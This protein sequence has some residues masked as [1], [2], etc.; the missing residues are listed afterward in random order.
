M[1][2]ALRPYLSGLRF[3]VVLLGT[4]AVSAVR[5]QPTTPPPP[6]PPRAVTL[7]IPAERT[8]GNG[9]R[10]IAVER[11][12]VPLVTVQLVL[13]S[14]G[15]ADPPGLAGAA[16]LTTT[17]MTRGTATRS[18]PEIAGAMEA[19]GTSLDAS[20]VWD[21]SGLSTTVMAPNLSPALAILSDVALHPAFAADELERLR[22]QTVGELRLS[23]SEPGVLARLVAARLVFGDG[24]YG[25]PLSGTP[26]SVARITRDD[27]ARV[28]ASIYRPDNAVLVFSGAVAPAEAFTLAERFFGAWTS[29]AGSPAPT[30]APDA[31]RAVGT[32]GPRVVVVDMPQAGQAAVVVAHASL[33]RTDPSYVRGLVA[34]SV[35]GGGYSARLNQE[36]RIKRGL[37]YGAGSSF[38][39]RR[40]VGPFVASAQTKNESAAEVAR[41][42]AAEV[43]R[44][45]SE[46]VTEGELV[47]RKAVLTGGFA[48]GLETTGGYVSQIANLA[49]YGLPLNEIN[50]YIAQ[51]QAVSAGD[52]QQFAGR[53]LGG[54]GLTVVVVGDAKK[55]QDDLRKN[56]PGAVVEV[57]PE[58]KLDLNRASLRRP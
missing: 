27:L 4:V 21:R 50:R 28:H 52:V 23:A 44:L 33:A 17:L 54:A 58:A 31:P 49:L 47:P 53:R 25:H 26:E 43:G 14:G 13:R 41:I 32:T 48:R 39:A 10:V 19:L 38:D 2:H 11:A 8:L 57:I 20:A 15:E 24:P 3:A 18:A 35:L 30:I 51:V 16:Q 5:A 37:S 45:G 56:F 34:N 22:Q 42:L 55:F 29:P 12:G 7:P 36:I 6:G 9:L 1:P 40:N 46:A